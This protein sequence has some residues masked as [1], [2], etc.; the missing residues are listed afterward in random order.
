[1]AYWIL[2]TI[3]I[4]ISY[5]TIIVTFK[6]SSLDLKRIS[7]VDS[8]TYASSTNLFTVRCLGRQIRD[9][10]RLKSSLSST[11]SSSR[12]QPNRAG[13]QR[14]G[15]PLERRASTS[16]VDLSGYLGASNPASI[17]QVAESTRARNLVAGNNPKRTFKRV[18]SS[19]ALPSCTMTA[20]QHRFA[21]TDKSH[22]MVDL[23]QA[24]GSRRRGGGT[25]TT[26]SMKH[27]ES[28]NRLRFCLV[29]TSHMTASGSFRPRI[30]KTL[31]NLK[32][33]PQHAASSQLTRAVLQF[34]LAKMSF[35]L[36]LLW[37]VSWTPIA[38]L[39]MINSVMKCPR[40][41]ATAVFL[42]S[43][44]TKL[45]PALDVFIYGI[46]HPKIKSRFKL[47]IGKLLSL[48]GLCSAASMVKIRQ[49]NWTTSS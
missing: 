13:S 15:C 19:S 33:F 49:N 17:Q 44:M 27:T 46:S 45:G 20:S 39:A 37:L 25:T 35:Y 22:G 32:A 18:V 43:T 38:S 31:S 41:S 48:N 7:S 23:A 16:V 21:D 47:I 34:R 6:K 4:S 12:R 10:L 8:D 42:A 40:V 24:G 30:I 3:L 26:N 9:S 11:S 1:M 36:I 5:I 28:N 2:P 29:K 14:F